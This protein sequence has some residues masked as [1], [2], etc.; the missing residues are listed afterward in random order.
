MFFALLSARS[1]LPYPLPR[2]FRRGGARTVD[3]TRAI[4]ASSSSNEEKCATCPDATCS[5]RPATRPCVTSLFVRKC[6]TNAR[7]TD[8]GAYLSVSCC[9]RDLLLAR[10]APLAITCALCQE[11]SDTTP[12]SP[13]K[14]EGFLGDLSGIGWKR[15]MQADYMLSFGAYRL[16]LA[17]ARLWRGKQEVRLTGKAFAVLRHLATHTGELVTKDDLFQAVWPETVV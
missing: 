10:H 11:S 4:K 17:G 3:S 8:N 14:T 13:G 1:S 2:G 9:M 5:T 15:K 16:D 12:G 6:T 7:W